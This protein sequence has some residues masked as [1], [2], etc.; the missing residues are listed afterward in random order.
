MGN[1][2]NTRNL[3][4]EFGE[5]KQEHNIQHTD[6]IETTDQTCKFFL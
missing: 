5:D 1:K 4:Y 6:S 3:E 2:E